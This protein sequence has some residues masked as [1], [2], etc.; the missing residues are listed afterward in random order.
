MKYGLFIT[1]DKTLYLT[2]PSFGCSTSP[3]KEKLMMAISHFNEY[4]IKTVN[5]PYIYNQ[6]D[7]LSST[8]KEC[9]N[10]FMYAYKNYDYILSVGGG[11]AMIQLLPYIDFDELKKLQPK[12]FMGYSDNTILTFLLPTICDVASVYGLNAPGFGTTS[13]LPYQKDQLD[14]MLGKKLSF[15]GYEKYEAISLRTEDNPCIEI[16]PTEPSIITSYPNNNI[17]LTG[18]IIGGCIDVLSTIIG[19]K[20]DNV[21]NFNN[22]Y[23]D[24]LWFFEAC[25]MTP[26]EVYR[27]LLQMKYSGWFNNA[28]GFLFGRPFI[29]DVMFNKTYK[30]Y[31]I[32]ALA[33]LKLP[34][35]FDLDIG[36]VPPQIPVI[37]GS[38]ATIKVNDSK[39]SIS[40][41][42]K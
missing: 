23:D 15:N 38:V 26:I 21:C 40:Y 24:L 2:S 1:A 8:P 27:R 29:R 9:A 19:T 13:L 36:H 7:L 32:D 35:I 10:D 6:L 16:N 31:I 25:D 34:I 41:E 33:D 4:K 39:Y 11:E 18:R 14:L 28:K 42:L 5:G 30:D 37:V 20:Y 22:K 3:Y 17:T 12:L